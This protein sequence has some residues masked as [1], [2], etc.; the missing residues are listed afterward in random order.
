MMA[1]IHSHT[2]QSHVTLALR[3]LCLGSSKC[4]L[5]ETWHLHSL[6]VQEGDLIISVLRS[7]GY[8]G[9]AGIIQ[10]GNI[11]LANPSHYGLRLRP[12]I[13]V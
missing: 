9:A 1:Y 12:F 8:P 3:K 13:R 2:K 11:A 4:K 6:L 10:V 5:N 7:Q